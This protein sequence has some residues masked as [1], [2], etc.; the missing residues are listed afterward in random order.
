MDIH[1]YYMH[2]RSMQDVQ[3]VPSRKVLP[4]MYT[5]ILPS[6]DAVP[7]AGSVNSKINK[8]IS[9]HLVNNKLKTDR[10]TIVQFY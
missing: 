7:I 6:T 10:A 2:I 9:V 1:A 4:Y 8:F 5:Y 3:L